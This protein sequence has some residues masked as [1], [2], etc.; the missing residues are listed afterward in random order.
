VDYTPSDG[1][2]ERDLRD[3]LEFLLYLGSALTA[4]GEAVNRIEE[5]LRRVAAAYGAPRL[6][7]SVLPTYLVIALEPGRPATLEP[8]RALRGTLRLDQTAALFDVLKSAE[9]GDTRPADGIRRIVAIVDMRARFSP[10]ITVMG[11]VVLTVGICALL[12]PTWADIA[13]AA[14]FGVLVGLFKLIGVR[15]KSI[16]MIMPV[17]A[18]FAVAAITFLLAG[19]GWAEADL[20]AMVAPLVTFLPGA[21]LT[22]AVIDISAAEMVTGTSR[23]VAGSLQLLLLAFGIIG[24]AQVVGL[25]PPD[26]LIG[27]ADDPLG[28][29]APVLGVLAVGVGSYL[30]H[31]APPRS[32]GWLCLVLYAGWIGQY[33]GS[34]IFGSYLSGFVGAIVMTPLAYLVE[35]LPSGPPALVSFLP[36]FWMLVPG[37]LS[38]TGITEYLGH[39][40]AA[41]IQDLLG[42]LGS[43]V[44]IA[45]GVLCGY[46][47]YRALERSAAR[48]ADVRPR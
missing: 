43:M 48:L 11:H 17:T 47:L 44:A 19:W 14:L 21:A 37:A 7:V 2:D 8:T 38:L 13:L 34:E 22:M 42:A 27:R 1:T 9:R 3:L 32:L 5:R 25:P 33:L 39:D 26:D 45:L 12:Q 16:Q 36:A 46:P 15:W 35:R 40:A 4:A 29:W 24:A 30:H 18:A 10:V 20:R 23:L 31:S 28:V 41:G 6:R